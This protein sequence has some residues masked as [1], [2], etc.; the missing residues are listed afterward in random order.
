MKVSYV[1]YGN[2]EIIPFSRIQPIDERFCRLPCQAINCSLN[3]YPF[4]QQSCLAHPHNDVWSDT[5]SAWLSSL[6][7]GKSIEVSISD[8]LQPNQVL[9]EAFLPNQ[10]LKDSVFTNFYDNDT[11]SQ[12]VLS[13][14]LFMSAVGFSCSNGDARKILEDHSCSRESLALA[15]CVKEDYDGLSSGSFGVSNI[16]ISSLPPLVLKLNSSLE[17]TC[18]VSH[19]TEDLLIYIHPVQA[20]LACVINYINDTLHDHYSA[21]E[22]RIRLTSNELKCGSICVI[23]SIEFQ[24]WC[25]GSIVS[26]RSDITSEEK[27][28]CLIFFIDYGGS[29]LVDISD[30]FCLINS[31][32]GYPAQAVCCNLDVK[33]AGSSRR[34]MS[35][36]DI[37]C[38][39]ENVPISKKI[40]KFLLQCVNFLQHITDDRQLV[41]VLKGEGKYYFQYLVAFLFLATVRD[42][43][44]DYL[45]LTIKI[46]HMLLM[47][48]YDTN[49]EYD[50]HINERLMDYFCHTQGKTHICLL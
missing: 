35:N 33:C 25:R 12:D 44:D 26:I 17:F 15:A 38:D 7:L 42:D 8:C 36:P 22:N 27:V 30:I 9:L 39:V 13:L 45:L 41:G 46:D 47:D 23:Y 31:L 29:E 48:L 20:D 6:L 40:E 4:Q 49:G 18:L 34:I 43:S 14:S 21:E 24:Q 2:Q 19:I 32:S 37:K 3:V 11:L 28:R 1:D 50:K 16:R 10:D 5:I